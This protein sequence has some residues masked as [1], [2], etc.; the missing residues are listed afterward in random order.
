[1]NAPGKLTALHRAILETLDHLDNGADAFELVTHERCGTVDIR[2]FSDAIGSL[3]Y[4]GL[5]ERELRFGV[6]EAAREDDS[7]EW[8][9]MISD[10]GCEALDALRRADAVAMRVRPVSFAS[11]DDMRRYMGECSFDENAALAR[12]SESDRINAERQSSA[13][14]VRH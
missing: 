1:M 13:S 6:I 14:S 9:Y 4:L 11:R 7:L 8:A 3:E 10:A 5:I 12:A 2:A